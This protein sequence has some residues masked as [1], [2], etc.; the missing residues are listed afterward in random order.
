[1]KNPFLID[2]ITWND[3]NMEEVFERINHAS[4]AVGQEYLKKTLQS[5]VFDTGLLNQRD[6]KADS[7]STQDAAVSSLC[8]AFKGLGKPKKVSFLEHIFKIREVPTRSNGVHFLLIVLLLASIALIFLQPAIGIIAFVVMIILNIALYFRFKSEVEGYFQSLKYLVSMV[9]C[10]EKIRK[11]PLPDVFSEDK[12]ILSEAVRIFRPLKRGS[13]LITNS[14]SGSLIDVIMDYI[15][16]IFHVDLIK[17]NSMKKCAENNEEEIQILYNTLG[18]MET[19][20]CIME[21]RKEAGSFC[22]PVFSS[23]GAEGSLP[24]INAVNV[25]HPLVKKPVKNSICTNRSVLLTG[26]NASGKSTFLKTIAINQIFAQTICTCLA[27]RFE[28]GWFRILSSMAL[29]DNIL[30]NESYFIV[31]IKSLKR[32]FDA[33]DPEVPVLAFV[34]EVLR[35]TNTAERIAASSQL[36]KNLS[37]KNALVFAAT[38]DMELTSLLASDMDNFHFEEQVEGNSVLFDY[39][40]KEGRAFSRNA[41]ALLRS[42]GFDPEITEAAEEM[43]K[44]FVSSVEG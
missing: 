34:D 9:I 2:E 36:L 21:F 10:A 12:E 41:I 18:E 24:R 23:D 4:S 16:M 6:L 13:W 38:H 11:I 35:G 25:Y 27:D 15:R 31:E 39:R 17:F 30:G 8:K 29:K 44:Q 5:P 42:Y 3:L 14:V 33:L 28:T 22:R 20:I 7:L 32:I 37:R 40:L 1:M 26:S 43:A 19:A